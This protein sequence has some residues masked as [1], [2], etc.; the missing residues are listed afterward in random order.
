MSNVK[1]A[2]DYAKKV[3]KSLNDGGVWAHSLSVVPYDEVG[4]IIAEYR[5]VFSKV[6]F[7]IFTRSVLCTK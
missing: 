4:K 3:Q 1:L 7:N 2:R 5:K 6:E